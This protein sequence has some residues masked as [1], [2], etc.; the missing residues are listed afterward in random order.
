MVTV[1]KKN[2]KG[3]ITLT[4]T[5][6]EPGIKF[7]YPDDFQVDDGL[8]TGL[9]V[10]SKKYNGFMRI[11]IL[12]DEVV[13]DVENTSSK[14]SEIFVI[15]T[16]VMMP[17]TW[18]DKPDVKILKSGEYSKFPNSQEMLISSANCAQ[19][20]RELEWL[21]LIPVGQHYVFVAAEKAFVDRKDGCEI[22]SS[23]I[24]DYL[25]E[26]WESIVD[27]IEFDVD[28]I[29]KIASAKVIEPPVVYNWTRK[30]TKPRH[31]NYEFMAEYAYVGLHDSATNLFIADEDDVADMEEIV[32]LLTDSKFVKRDKTLFLCPDHID[33]DVSTDVYLCPSEPNKSEKG[34]DHIIEGTIGL[35]SGTLLAATGVAVD[36]GPDFEVKLKEGVYKFRVY[37]SGLMGDE[38]DDDYD[39]EKSE[40][41]KIYFW[42]TD[43]KETNEVKIIKPWNKPKLDD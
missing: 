5:Y 40:S 11:R 43:E 33:T 22:T 4:K 7:N 31:F 42:P 9:W 32:D 23:E 1:V 13:C 35:E 24:I 15:R 26:A 30:A 6:S 38:D 19:Y 18:S 34:F 41:W 2:N 27:S 21:I 36:D 20:Y 39:D 29:H 37:F 25:K 17:D 3:D 8:H 10:N 16:I 14:P 28:E 12:E